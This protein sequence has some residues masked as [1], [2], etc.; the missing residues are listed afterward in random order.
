MRSHRPP[1]V[2]H[3]PASSLHLPSSTKAMLLAAG[4]GTRLRPLTDS[5]P[6]CM[7]PVAGKPV[8]Q[9]NVEWLRSQGVVDLVVNLHYHPE[10][11]TD[12]FGDGSAFGVRIHY[13][14]EPELLG[15][16][17]ALWAARQFFSQERFLVLYADNLIDCDLTRLYD[18][19]MASRATLTMALFWRADVSASGVV[20]LDENGRISAFK[21][22]PKPEEALSHWVNA[23]LLLCEPGVPRFIPPEQPSDFGH[24]VL[25]AL[26][27]AGELLYGYTMGPD[28]GLWWIDTAEDLQQVRE[29]WKRKNGERRRRL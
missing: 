2:I 28:E 14:Y 9:H 7:V 12:H 16:A 29:E 6:K 25:P 23:G 11:V 22:K 15:T 27:A 24:D 4:P 18:L 3:P 26:L 17:G 19:H 10:T 8:L 21:E 13:S 20:S 1:S 5:L